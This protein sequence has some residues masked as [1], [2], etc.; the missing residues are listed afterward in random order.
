MEN[1]CYEN[2]VFETTNASGLSLDGRNLTT[3]NNADKDVSTYKSDVR[4][5]FKTSRLRIC[6]GQI[7]SEI[8]IRVG[9]ENVQKHLD[10]LKALYGLLCIVVI[11]LMMRVFFA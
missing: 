3:R 5:D 6:Y 7:L 2:H 11:L 8:Q 10:V 4:L 9:P 1:I